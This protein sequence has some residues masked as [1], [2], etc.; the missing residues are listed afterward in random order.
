M[1]ELQT[2]FNVA[3]FYDDYD[4][5]KQYYRILFR[6]STA[7]QARELTQLQTILQKQVSRFGD[8]IYKDGSIVEGCNFTQYPNIQQ[9]KFKDSNT[10]TLDF[11]TLT[12]GNYDPTANVSH[13]SNSHLLVSNT[14]GLR[15]AVFEA[16]IGAE[17]AVDAGSYDT[18][19][20]Y[21][22]YLNSGNSAGTPVSTF[23]TTSEM[24]DVYSSS[25]DKMGPLSYSNYLGSLYTLSSNST[26]NALGVGHGIHVGQGII[27]QKGFFIKSN[28]GNFII[29]EHSSN[30]SGIKVGFSTSEYIVKPS[31]DPSLYDNSIGSPNYSAPGA[32]R[33]KLVPKLVAYDSSNNSVTIP[34][35]FLPV[36]DFSQ[37]AGTT[38]AITAQDPIYS[39]IGDMIAQ[40]T[41]EE[42]GDYVVKPFQVNVE[43]S[44]NPNTFYYTSSPGI[45]YIDGY[46]VEY[47]AARRIEVP[48]GITSQ[49]LLDEIATVNFGNYIFVTDVAG[50]LD[51]GGLPSINIY[52][53]PQEVMSKN[54]SASAPLGTLIGTATVNTI[55]FYSGTK[56][57]SSA[58]YRLY[59]T[60]I[61]INAGYSFKADAKSFYV[62]GTYGK[63]FADIVL[64]NGNAQIQSNIGNLIFD[65]GLTGVRRLTSNT[66]VND[67][68]YVYRNT[69]SSA[70]L[71]RSAGKAT[72]TFSIASDQ[73]NYGAGTID[74]IASENINILFNNDV[75]ANL[76]SSTVYMG[77]IGGVSNVTHSN[78]VVSSVSAGFDTTLK[79]GNNI[80]LYSATSGTT[81]HTI[82][83]V[84][85]ANSI[86]LTPNVNPTPAGGSISIYRFFKTGT[87]ID[88][89]G[90]GNTITFSSVAGKVTQ[91]SINVAI[92]PDTVTTYSVRA[93][94]PIQRST[95]VPIKKDV[96]K[97]RFVNINCASHS[98]GTLGPWSLGLPDVYK[99]TGIHV[100]ANFSNTNPNRIDWFT[101]NN[102]QD[103]N[104]YGL[105]SIAVKPQYKSGLTSASRMTIQLNHFTPN[106][107]SSQA[108][109]MSVD[110]YPID[111]A[112]TANTSAIV[113]AEIP[114]YKDISGNLY[115]LRNYIDVRPIL[116]NTAVSA[117]TSATATINPANNTTTFYT[118]VLKAA[119][120]PDSNFQYNAEFYLPRYDALLVTKTGALI[121]KSGTPSFNP[122]PPA[123]N[124][125]GL[126]IADIYVPPYPSLTFSEAE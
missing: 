13:L 107:S 67:T 97:D 80:K 111:D 73:F 6:P 72:A 121:V 120:E 86:T 53:T 74:D 114:V 15:A 84:N 110:S 85:S 113:T 14:T 17:S 46:R 109:F 88:F 29:K 106:I 103:D 124:S 65:T 83:A 24:I 26:V 23:S 56:G 102:G 70:N 71:N 123:L 60:N 5:N 35:G 87:P 57:T 34:E 99:I 9:V 52:N 94:A 40:R 21:I 79:V 82:T 101:I 3:P 81:Y 104:Y 105:A 11:T 75:T 2:N 1:A 117:T 43:A 33:L 25:Q 59:I 119:I 27:Y 8:S 4:E 125:S 42:S 115:D 36:I 55:K 126:K 69:S 30:V 19:R 16:I 61:K 100:G 92:D 18:N 98:A 45:G 108:T 122:K 22:L 39:I 44:S 68:T 76:F 118:S 93:Q 96:K 12:L 48:R 66:G 58:I 64:T 41:K 50:I 51:V 91:M 77:S 32:Y 38:A 28:P 116:T 89:T 95:A 90:S 78:V 63:V 54:I 112:N 20:A 7:V 37:T 10:S 49:D 62:N 47:Q 31:E